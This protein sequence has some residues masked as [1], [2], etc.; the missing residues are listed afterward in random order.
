MVIGD[1]KKIDLSTSSFERIITDGNLYVDKTRII[2]NFLE[3][4]STVQ[5]I[6]RQR[7]LGKSLNMDTLRCF[8]TNH[9]D[10][11]HLFKGLYIESRPAWNY[12]NSAPVFYF[13]FKGL[14]PEAYHKQIIRQVSRHISNLVNPDTLTGYFKQQYDE[15]VNDINLA[16][17]S[18]HFLTELAYE[19]TGK[20]SYLLIDEYDKLLMENYKS[21]KYEEIRLFEASLLSSA[22]KGNQYLEKALLTGVMRLS[23]ESMFS[24]LNNIVT[25]DVFKDDVYTDDYGLTETEMN[26]LRHLS[27]FD[28]DEVRSWYNGIRIGK[29]A[30]YNTYSVMS[31]LT[32]KQYECFWGKSGTLDAIIGMMNDERKPVMAKLLNHEIVEVEMDSRISLVRLAADKGSKAF[33]S[34]LVQCGYLALIEDMYSKGTALVSIPNKELMIVWKNFILDSLF[35]NTS[36][37]RTLFDNADNLKLFSRDVEY[38]LSD[39]FSYHDLSVYDGSNKARTYERVYHVFLLGLLSAYEDVR[40]KFA[41]SN[42]ESGD[43]RYDVLVERESANFIFEVKPC[44][45]FD[46]LDAQAEKALAQI[47]T[48]RYGADLA[49]QGKRLVKIGVT[50]C[51]KQCRVM[52]A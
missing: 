16:T 42:R 51:G 14:K 24:G 1:I 50:V 52:C 39:R 48:K 4:T 43:G 31:F 7:R 49:F 46:E 22:L 28:M 15:I 17:D 26:E 3:S 11:R 30:I 2:E 21:A 10:L 44:D 38:F 27:D 35:E 33:Y 9:E 8:L 47:E 29:R 12:A 19:V 23:H 36:Q 6:A 34:L 37:V 32:Y 18:L 5:L 45:S 41:L 40:F 25:F 13:D 20:R